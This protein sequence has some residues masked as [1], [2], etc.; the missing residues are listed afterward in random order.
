MIPTTL[1]LAALSGL[2]AS[3]SSAALVALFNFDNSGNLGANTGLATTEWN[4]FTA[5][6]SLDAKFGAGSGNFAP[7]E[8]WDADFGGDASVNMSSFTVSMHIKGGDRAWKDY[9]SIGTGNNVVHVLEQTGAGGLA[10][11]NINNVGGNGGTA[12]VYNGIDL[13]DGGWHHIGLT[14]GA[15]AITIYVDG[16]ARSSGAYTGSGIASAFQIGGRFGDG[17]RAMVAL[18][19]DVAVYNETLSEGQMAWL[20]SNAA[21]NNPVPEPGAALLGGLGLLGLLRRRRA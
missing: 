6:Q 4:S 21:V 10:N 3:T 20:S 13:T 15:G 16:I 19:D 1:R 12:G 7:S 5:T 9:I 17:A 2:L 14:V 18:I 11:Y 8:A